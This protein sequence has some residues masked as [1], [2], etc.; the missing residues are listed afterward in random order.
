MSTNNNLN[1]INSID[2]VN[3]FDIIEKEVDPMPLIVE[4]K[5]VEKENKYLTG[6]FEIFKS[7]LIDKG[8]FTGAMAFVIGKLLRDIIT[9]LVYLILTFITWGLSNYFKKKKY[10]VSKYN[11][12][13]LDNI[14][15]SKENLK[16]IKNI[17][18]IERITSFD[19]DTCN[20]IKNKYNVTCQQIN[21]IMEDK[22][23][24]GLDCDKINKM[25]GKKS[26][27]NIKKIIKKIL[28]GKENVEVVFSFKLIIQFIEFFFTYIILAVSYNYIIIG[29][30]DKDP[31]KRK[32]IE[33]KTALI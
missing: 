6:T 18:N 20:K 28:K 2:P 21:N 23:T 1:T 8:V 17:K 27:S 24:E 16:N 14:N 22:D 30:L 26:C 11:L 33:E 9:E 3:K 10:T 15:T 32:E 12:F 25:F 31:P 29:M 7:V 5:I 19:D 4:D 13:F